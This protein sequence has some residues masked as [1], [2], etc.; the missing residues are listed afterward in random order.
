MTFAQD[1][2]DLLKL[3]DSQISISKFIHE[4]ALEA[5][6]IVRCP[7]GLWFHNDDNPPDDRV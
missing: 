1:P 3:S 4:P 6:V 2:L 7:S 5:K